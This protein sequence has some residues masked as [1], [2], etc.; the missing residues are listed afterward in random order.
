MRNPFAH[1][2]ATCAPAPAASGVEGGA[3]RRKRAVALLA[4]A[5]AWAVGAASA[6]EQKPEPQPQPP[7][8]ISEAHTSAVAFAL[9]MDLVTASLASTCAKA[10]EALSMAAQ[11]ARSQWIAHNGSLVSSAHDYLRFLSAVVASE[12]GAEAGQAFYEQQKARYVADA[13]TALTETFPDG[14]I[15]EAGCE[16]VIGKLGTGGMNLD[17]K[18]QL[19]ESLVEIEDA[20]TQLRQQG[21]GPR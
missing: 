1:K 3:I 7:S 19:H 10:S 17:A 9:T 6:Q 13:H 8:A 15:D 5:C 12:Q 16:E 14:G 20:I 21:G 18:P 11:A 2:S 4:L